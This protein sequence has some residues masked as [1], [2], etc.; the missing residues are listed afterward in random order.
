MQQISKRQ[1]PAI[2]KVSYSNAGRI[3]FPTPRPGVYLKIRK[4][5]TKSELAIRK[6][7]IPIVV[8]NVLCSAK[9][10]VSPNVENGNLLAMQNAR[11][12]V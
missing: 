7:T 6:N 12:I 9:N 3:S 2:G 8:T 5:I 4:M 11:L 1:R 10:R